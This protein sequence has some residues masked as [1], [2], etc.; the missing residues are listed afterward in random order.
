MARRVEKAKRRQAAAL[1]NAMLSTRKCFRNYVSIFGWVAGK[2]K[3]ASAVV[4][5]D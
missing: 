3:A 5:G 2:D 1:Q 4:D